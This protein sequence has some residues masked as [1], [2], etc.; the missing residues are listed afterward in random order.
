MADTESLKSYKP[1]MLRQM[2]NDMLLIRRFE[3]EASKRY[4][5]REFGGFLH[6]YIGQ[7]AIA[8]GAVAAVDL[9]KDY[10]LTAYRDHGFAL[11]VGM[12]P[13]CVMAELYGRITGCSRGKGGSMHMFDVSRHFLGGNGIVGAHIPLATGV[14]LKIAYMGE[15]AAVLCFFGD[16]AIHQGTF[17]ESA[18]IAKVW[19]LP[20]VYICENNQYG[21]GTDYRRVSAISEYARLSCAFDF[22]GK[23]IDGMDVLAVYNEIKEAAARAREKRIPSLIDAK[24]YRYVGHSISDP[25]T[26]RTRDEVEQFRQNDPILI[27]KNKLVSAGLLNEEDYKDMDSKCRAAVAEAVKFARQSPDPEIRTIY[28][29]IYA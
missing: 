2:L 28:E 19:N 25:A 29:D 17:Y 1:E 26:Y 5:L 22:P 14:A 23:Q 10:I 13:K 11:A 15:S 9:T 8:V 21:M 6:L 24:T 20:I 27:L 4:G 16:G 7:E 18:N 12:D 3:E